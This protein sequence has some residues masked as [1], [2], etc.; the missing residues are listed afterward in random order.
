MRNFVKIACVI[1][2]DIEDMDPDLIEET[3]AQVAKYLE[4]VEGEI[5]N[6]EV[7][8]IVAEAARG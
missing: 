7:M 2:V 6:S 5:P 3:K 8:V 1:E 4:G